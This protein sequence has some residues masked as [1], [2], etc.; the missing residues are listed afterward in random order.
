[1]EP[2]DPTAIGFLLSENRSM[3]MHVG[4]L[5]LFKKPEGAGRNYVRE[6]YESDARRRRDRA[7]VPQAPAPLAEDRRAARLGRGRAVRHRAPRPPQR[8]AQAGPGARAARPVL[9]AAQHP[10]RLGAARCGRRTS[11]RACATAGWRCTP[12]LHH[13]LVDGVS[14]MRLLQ[15]VLST[16]P[17]Q[18]DMP[19]PVGR[20]APRRPSG[21]R[22]G[23]GR[24]Q[25]A[26]DVPL[27]RAPHGARHRRRGRRPARGAGPDAQPQ[28]AQRDLGALALRPA[29][30]PQ[31]EDHRRPAGSPPRTG[32]SSGCGRSARPPAPPSTTSCWPCAAARCGP[33]CSSSTPCPTPRWSS[34]V[35]VGL[36][37]KQSQRRLGRGRQRRRL[38]HGQARHRP[39]R[40]RRRGC[41][42]STTR[43]ATARRRCRR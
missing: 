27:Q 6:L 13:A 33:T 10:P 43:C 35:P 34:M 7:A 11:S 20:P 40:P 42:R 38:G 22:P 14:A 30:D 39:R 21:Q 5:Q 3:P 17:D 16:D 15:S 19:A 36:N 25:P 12:R 26:T 8:A 1:M 18:R 28:P 24:A 37:A 29:H 41:R 31:P 9:A 4:G 23:R 32:R 2:I